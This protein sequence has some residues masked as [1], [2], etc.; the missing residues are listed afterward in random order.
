MG[1]QFIYIYKYIGLLLRIYLYCVKYLY[2]FLPCAGAF[3]FC[4]FLFC[5]TPT[6]LALYQACL[7][8]LKAECALSSLETTVAFSLRGVRWKVMT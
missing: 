7:S 2:H 6:N 8:F 5:L 1:R 3:C 4:S